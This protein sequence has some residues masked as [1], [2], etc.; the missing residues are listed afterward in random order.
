MCGIAGVFNWSD[1]SGFD[2][3]RTGCCLG[4]ALAHRGPDGEGTVCGSRCRAR[5][6]PA[7]HHR[8]HARRPTADDHARRALLDRLQRRDFQL[9][10]PARQSR[11][12]GR[13]FITASDTEVLLALIVRDGI[14]ALSR[15][16]GMFALAIWDNTARTLTVARDRFGIKPLYI[17]A[18]PGRVSVR[19]RDRRAAQSRARRSRR[20]TCRRA[21]AFWPG[22]TS[23]H[24]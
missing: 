15:A 5:P 8:S 3:P 23:L 16:R 1:P 17:A 14:G 9:P 6:S 12:G 22:A 13:R 20:V 18:A 7:R 2:V 4:A 10:R 24:R 11:A 19:L 21:S